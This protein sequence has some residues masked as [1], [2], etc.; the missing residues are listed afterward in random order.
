MPTL[1]EILTT[2][3]SHSLISVLPQDGSRLFKLPP[4]I[5][6]HI[7]RLVVAAEDDPSRPFEVNSHYCRPGQQAFKAINTPLL[8]VCRRIYLE[9]FDLPLSNNVMTFW[10]YRGPRGE[11]D[12]AKRRGEYHCPN[13]LH[14][15]PRP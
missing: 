3:Q 1:A 11:P 6:E 4:E 2:Q 5:R 8:L 12:I 10:C 9:T 15:Q 13:V 14:V 7:W